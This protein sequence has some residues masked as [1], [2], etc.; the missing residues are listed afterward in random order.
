MQ[1]GYM[2]MYGDLFTLNSF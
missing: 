2:T 1:S